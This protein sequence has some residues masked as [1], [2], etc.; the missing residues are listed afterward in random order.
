V[1]G[2]CERPSYFFDVVGS[3]LA[4]VLPENRGLGLGQGADETAERNHPAFFR[5]VVGGYRSVFVAATMHGIHDASAA[6]QVEGAA[7]GQVVGERRDARALQV[8]G[9]ADGQVVGER[10]DARAPCRSREPEVDSIFMKCGLVMRFVF[11]AR[12]AHPP[13]PGEASKFAR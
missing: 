5:V 6:P 3:G 7:D 8:E 10:R 9:A 12:N 1:R 4:A 13:V 2:L 11:P